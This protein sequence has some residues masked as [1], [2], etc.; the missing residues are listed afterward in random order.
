MILLIKPISRSSIF[1]MLI[2]SLGWCFMI[3]S[4]AALMASVRRGVPAF[5][6]RP[7]CPRFVIEVRPTGR[8]WVSAAK[9]NEGND[10]ERRVKWHER[11]GRRESDGAMAPPTPSASVLSAPRVFSFPAKGNVFNNREKK[12]KNRASSR[13]WHA[14]RRVDERLA[15]ARQWN[16]IARDAII[17]GL[18]RSTHLRRTPTTEPCPC[19]KCSS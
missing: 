14:R 16:V 5:H 15:G 6:L 4:E 8:A 12:G 2:P 7:L 11:P 3:S 10:D 17:K 19:H 18:M 9:I 1:F 13:W